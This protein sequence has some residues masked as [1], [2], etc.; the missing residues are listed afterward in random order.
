MKIRQDIHGA[1]IVL[2]LGFDRLKDFLGEVVI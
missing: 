1:A 2:D